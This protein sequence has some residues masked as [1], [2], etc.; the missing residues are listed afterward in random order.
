MNKEFKKKPDCFYCRIG[1][2]G[3]YVEAGTEQKVTAFSNL[4]VTLGVG[5][6]G[7]KLICRFVGNHIL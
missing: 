1:T 3:I 4:G 7:V 5:P 6:N 2:E